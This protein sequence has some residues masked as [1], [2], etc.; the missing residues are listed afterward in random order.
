MKV[1]GKQFDPEKTELPVE[2]IKHEVFGRELSRLSDDD[3][4]CHGWVEGGGG[5]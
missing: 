4:V 5:P 3:F 1:A 2:D